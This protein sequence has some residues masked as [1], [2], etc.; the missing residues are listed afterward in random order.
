MYIT[1]ASMPST[2]GLLHSIQGL[3]NMIVMIRLT[4]IGETKRLTQVYLLIEETIEKS[5][6]D[7]KLT[8]VPPVRKS[9]RAQ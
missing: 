8:E 3:D 9:H 4:R 5:I 2:G 1:K 6:L 7:I